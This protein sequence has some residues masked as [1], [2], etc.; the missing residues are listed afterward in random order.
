M[1]R[2]HRYMRDTNPANFINATDMVQQ[3]QKFKL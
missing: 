3:I 2:G 1:T